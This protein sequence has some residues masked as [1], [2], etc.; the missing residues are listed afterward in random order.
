MNR[1]LNAPV[2]CYESIGFKGRHNDLPSSKDTSKRHNK[3]R[4]VQGQVHIRIRKRTWNWQERL[5][6]GPHTAQQTPTS[7]F[8]WNPLTRHERYCQPGLWQ[9]PGGKWISRQGQLTGYRGFKWALWCFYAR[10]R[11]VPRLLWGSISS[12][13]AG[14]CIGLLNAELHKDLLL[15][16]LVTWICF[17]CRIEKI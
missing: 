9:H 13:L 5:G 6:N 16:R 14:S 15:L 10:P 17:K 4:I 2:T 7:G 11:D 1:D 3:V 12:H 8:S